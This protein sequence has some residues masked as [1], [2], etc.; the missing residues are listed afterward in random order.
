M[1]R[2][3]HTYCPGTGSRG[4]TTTAGRPFRMAT[5]RRAT[6]AAGS[7]RPADA[8]WGRVRPCEAVQLQHPDWPGR[9]A[10]LREGT[11]SHPPPPPPPEA[12]HK[13]TRASSPRHAPRI[14]FGD[15]RS[16]TP[17]PN[18]RKQSPRAPSPRRQH[19]HRSTSPPA[20]LHGMAP[21]ASVPGCGVGEIPAR[22]VASRSLALPGRPC[23]ILQER[24]T[25]V[26][27]RRKVVAHV[28]SDGLLVRWPARTDCAVGPGAERR[29]AAQHLMHG[30]R[31]ALDV[32]RGPTWGPGSPCS[33]TYTAGVE[34]TIRCWSRQAGS[35]ELAEL[36]AFP[37]Q[38]VGDLGV[39]AQSR[40]CQA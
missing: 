34:I 29:L 39:P 1:R 11:V 5:P 25:A 24:R 31:R 26:Q 37:T 13:S 10:A 4:P 20:G 17:H 22:A 40:D 9:C 38:G 15:Q 19:R 6:S 18:P 7:D 36:S 28:S 23:W 30:E 8:S 16:R 32:A 14:S 33:G 12:P 21:L 35:V 3:V 2:S 27:R